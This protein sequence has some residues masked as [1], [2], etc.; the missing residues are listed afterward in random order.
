MSTFLNSLKDLLPLVPFLMLGERRVNSKANVSITRLVEA[1][2]I[3]GISGGVAVYGTTVRLAGELEQLG[4]NQI[5]IE[6]DVKEIKELSRQT[7]ETQI[8]VL[9]ARGV[10]LENIERKIEIIER[11]MK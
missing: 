7:R 8:R 9:E 10:R 11:K 4:K 3:A 6:A 2:I 1:F 5:R